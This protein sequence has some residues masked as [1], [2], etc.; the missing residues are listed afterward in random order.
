MTGSHFAFF[1][2][3]DTLI[4]AKSMFSFFR[5][6][7]QVRGDHTE[8]EVFENDFQLLLRKNLPRDDLN[9]AYYKYLAGAVPEELR[10]LGERWWRQAT[11]QPGIMIEPVVSLMRQLEADGFE[12]VFVSGSFQE[13]LTPIA[14]QLSVEHILCAPMAIGDDGL[15]TGELDAAPTIGHG[16]AEAIG[17]FLAERRA[18][19][20]ECWAIG[21]DV[22][23]IPMLRS[24]GR[25]GVV[26][27]DGPL[28]EL[29]R[30]EGWML[31]ENV[32]TAA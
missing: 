5:F 6:Y 27:L 18:D 9:R 23:D 8:L 26:G 32:A 19:A 7:C 30:T 13:I 10:S 24:V 11:A 2:V 1:D 25:R 14:R 29:A 3:D 12:P 16:K 28:A 20:A 21:D 4:H 22:S 17:A 31:V 15:Y